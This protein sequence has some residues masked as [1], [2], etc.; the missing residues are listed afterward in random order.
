MENSELIFSLDAVQFDT[1]NKY[2]KLLKP[3]DIIGVKVYEQDKEVGVIT[4]AKS[5]SGGL[6]LVTIKL[7]SKGEQLL[8]KVRAKMSIGRVL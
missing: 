3:K 5:V 4:K 6:L 7:S 2:D 8:E 1:L